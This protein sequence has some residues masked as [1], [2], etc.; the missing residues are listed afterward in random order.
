MS[1]RW[2][3]NGDLLCA[4]KH[5]EYKDDTYIDDRLHYQLSVKLKVVIPRDDENESGVWHWINEV[6]PIARRE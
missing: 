1:L 3:N 4:A 6:F 2:R 5:E